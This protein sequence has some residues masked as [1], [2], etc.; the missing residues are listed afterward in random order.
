MLRAIK[1]TSVFS[2]FWLQNA[3]I[4]TRAFLLILPTLADLLEMSR[5]TVS[6]Q[7][8]NVQQKNSFECLKNLFFSVNLDLD[9]VLDWQ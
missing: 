3:R 7:S 8:N 1:L 2:D 9:S 5:Y 6:F 4:S